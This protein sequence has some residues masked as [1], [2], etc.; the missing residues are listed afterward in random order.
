MH[1]QKVIG[2]ASKYLTTEKT[3]ELISALESCS[4]DLK[5]VVNEILQT[6]FEPKVLLIFGWICES[7]R[8]KLTP[9]IFGISRYSRFQTSRTIRKDLPSKFGM[10]SAT[11]GFKM[12]VFASAL[13]SNVKEVQ[14][15]SEEIRLS[16]PLSETQASFNEK[17]MNIEISLR[18]SLNKNVTLGE[19]DYIFLELRKPKTRIRNSYN[20]DVWGNLIP[21][22]ESTCDFSL[23]NSLYGNLLGSASISEIDL[24]KLALIGSYEKESDREKIREF[25][26]GW[27]RHK[28]Q[29]PGWIDIE[30]EH[31]PTQVV[32][33]LETHRNGARNSGPL[34]HV[35]APKAAYT[36]V[37]NAYVFRGGTILQGGRLLENDLA[38]RA[39]LGLVAGRWDYVVGSAATLEHVALK[40]P[41]STT[42]FIPRAIHLSSRADF[43]WFHWMIETMPRLGLVENVVDP[44]IPVIISDR[45]LDAAVDALKIYTD[46]D[47]I[48]VHSESLVEVG[49][50]VI[51]GPV[52]FHPDI[53]H[54]GW[55]YGCKLNF[56]EIDA[57]RDKL[58]RRIPA[59]DSPKK[60]F[61]T[62][63][64][65][66]RGLL[67]QESVISVA[68][69]KGFTLVDPKNLTLSEQVNVFR[70]ADHIA[71]PGGA[72]MANFMFMKPGSRITSFASEYA[73]DFLMPSVIAGHFKL[74]YEVFRGRAIGVKPTDKP[75]DKLHRDYKI[76]VMKLRRAWK[77]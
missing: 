70:N 24:V 2:S 52:I 55:E 7:E 30:P 34:V 16:D 67:N 38:Q 18:E 15:Q 35:R 37:E 43:N 22:I 53:A 32:P 12:E 77:V 71:S 75:M 6:T 3:S 28:V 61:W 62:R 36:V 19:L 5:N 45:L 29:L 59:R 10:K 69:E 13:W 49:E 41:T 72:A 57:V 8:H 33:A 63:S 23:A 50:L 9:E 26:S 46:R 14:L 73:Y 40:L 51:P 74:E 31:S 1:L 56:P 11:W 20:N 25:P 42:Q 48:K 76:P 17:K 39:A 21:L 4:W 64:G 27:T 60:V 68:L 65:G 47:I 66:A 58:M 54:P 44:T